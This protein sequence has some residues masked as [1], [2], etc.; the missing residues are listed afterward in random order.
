[1]SLVQ[2]EAVRFEI[3]AV[4]RGGKQMHGD[5]VRAVRGHGQVVGL[6][7]PGHLHEHRHPAAVGDVRLRKSHAARMDHLSELVQGMQILA[8]GHGQAAF[9]HDAGVSRHIVR[10]GR[11][12]QPH[13]LEGLERAGGADRLIG[14]P[15]HVGVHH[16]G[17][18]RPE[19]LAHGLHTCH[20][21]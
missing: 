6:G 15:A 19:V 12:F 14:G 7:E 18:I 4:G 13:G 2:P 5:V 21:L 20:V 3:G 10:N 11:L 16:E 8:R 1:M 9:P 17:K